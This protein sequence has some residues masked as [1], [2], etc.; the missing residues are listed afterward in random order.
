M[1]SS[2]RET[3]SPD[4]CRTLRAQPEWVLR[5]GT[6]TPGP[7]GIESTV[8]RPICPLCRF[9]LIF[10]DKCPVTKSR[11]LLAKE[12]ISFAASDDKNRN[13]FDTTKAKRAFIKGVFIIIW[14]I[15][16]VHSESVSTSSSLPYHVTVETDNIALSYFC[17]YCF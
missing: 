9:L 17:F 11:G 12:T 5:E 2:H 16:A 13:P 1:I 4:F 10:G 8:S 15:A 7:F 3:K 6:R 14:F